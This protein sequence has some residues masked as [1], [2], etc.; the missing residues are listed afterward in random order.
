LFK[1]R[2]QAAHEQPSYAVAKAAPK[3]VRAELIQVNASTVA[4]LD[5]GLEETLTLHQLGLSKE[6]GRSFKTT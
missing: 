4:T 1:R 5:E 2:S 6:L 3:R